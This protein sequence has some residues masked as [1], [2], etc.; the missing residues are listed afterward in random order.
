M[1]AFLEVLLKILAYIDLALIQLIKW[2]P[3]QLR[4]LFSWLFR[5]LRGKKAAQAKAALPDRFQ[6]L[7]FYGKLLLPYLILLGATI[8]LICF[9]FASRKG[10]NL[11]LELAYLNTAPMVLLQQLIAIPELGWAAIRPAALFAL[12]IPSVLV[13]FL[14]G[15]LKV[16]EADTYQLEPAPKWVTFLAYAVYTLSVAVFATLLEPLFESAGA[17]LTE[18][19][20]QFTDLQGQSFFTI[21]RNVLVLVVLGIFLL[22]G[23]LIGIKEYGEGL[24]YGLVG[25]VCMVLL[26]IILSLI[27][28]LFSAPS[29]IADVICGL[30]PIV[31]EGLRHYIAGLLE[32]GYFDDILGIERVQPTQE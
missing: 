8:F 21:L 11:L 1:G 14:V 9:L 17:F 5:K 10:G 2:I 29:S 26:W 19:F 32:N 22:W 6:K 24:F 27:L 16:K 28:Y 4:K 18:T 12:A 13:S 20:R 23:C 7:C 25:L 31:L 30:I 15:S 3:L